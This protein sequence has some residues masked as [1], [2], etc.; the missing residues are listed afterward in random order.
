MIVVQ[1]FLDPRDQVSEN[2]IM[3][4]ITDVSH[5]LSAVVLVAQVALAD[6]FNDVILVCQSF[7]LSHVVSENRKADVVVH[8]DHPADSVH[9]LGV[10]V[11]VGQNRFSILECFDGVR[12]MSSEM[13]VAS[14]ATVDDIRNCES[15][16]ASDSLGVFRNLLGLKKELLRQERGTRR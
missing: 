8:T 14:L 13:I 6:A 11:V 10:E 15:Q 2:D 9:N 3:G 16:N 4:I 7:G 12:E 1:Q 5:P